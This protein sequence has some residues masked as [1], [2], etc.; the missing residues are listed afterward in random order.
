MLVAWLKR[1]WLHAYVAVVG[2]VALATGFHHART[3]S[4][5]TIGDFLINYNA[6]FVRRGLI[7]AFGFWLA[8]GHVGID[9][10]IVF[11]IQVL[12]Y[13][14]FLIC[15]LRLIAQ[16][17]LSYSLIALV[18]SPAT[19]SFMLFEPSTAFRKEVLLFAVL[20]ALTLPMVR[21]LR[22]WQLSVLLSVFA[23]III[24]SH[25]GLFAY[26]PYLFGAVALRL[27]LRKA[28]IVSSV[29]AACAGG[30]VL[31]AITHPGSFEQAQAICHSLHGSLLSPGELNG[32]GVCD[33]GIAW[34]QVSTAQ[35]HRFIVDVEAQQHYF[36]IYGVL[37]VV[38]FFPVVVELV[39][40]FRNTALRG[41]AAIIAGCGCTSIMASI[42]LF[43]VGSDWGR[44]IEIHLVCLMLLLLTAAADR[45][46]CG[47]AAA[48]T[49]RTAV[50]EN[51]A[52]LLGRAAAVGG[53]LLYATTWNLPL[54][55]G[56]SFRGYF[57][58]GRHLV[59]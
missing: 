20:G 42:G 15:V 11:L 26:M 49:Q 37:A 2:C 58:L 3:G 45:S 21:W 36:R 38:A 59:R 39:R 28:F 50:L 43:Y 14:S 55:S 27:G 33:G 47:C 34:L 40:M 41:S 30:A 44:W 57:A 31:A 29:P 52:S 4:P 24:L 10:W 12:C 22:E 5:W 8:G 9:I 23:G 53:L 56:S 32:S 16:A 18:V 48:E 1:Y 7:G 54:F 25:E 6:G 19:L 17:R 13:L 35:A 46:R 51:S